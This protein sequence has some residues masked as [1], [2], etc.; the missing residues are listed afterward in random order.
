MERDDR[1]L[2][3][4]V[5]YALDALRGIDVTGLV[6]DDALSKLRSALIEDELL[7]IPSDIGVLVP[8]LGKSWSQ[9]A[10]LKVLRDSGILTKWQCRLVTRRKIFSPGPGGQLILSARTV[11][12]RLATI[13]LVV[14]AAMMA[15]W[16]AGVLALDEVG[17]TGITS[18]YLAGTLL[19]LLASPWWDFGF[20]VPRLIRQLQIANIPIIYG[21]AS[22]DDATQRSFA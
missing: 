20:G 8:L 2:H 6:Y 22:C 18:S 11:S 3:P 14:I 15:T 5:E 19:G 4:D 12:K 7:A 21:E 17:L 16:I 9:G 13:A 1:D 10:L